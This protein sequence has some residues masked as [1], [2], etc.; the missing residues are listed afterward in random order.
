MSVLPSGGCRG[1]L[2]G[3]GNSPVGIN[4]W[5]HNALREPLKDLI[6]EDSKYSYTFDKF[7][8]LVALGF[9]DMEG[10][11]FDNWFSLWFIHVAS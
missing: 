9:R 2:E 11:C 4:D 10:T 5:L 7:E 3:M 6:P 8:V 1:L